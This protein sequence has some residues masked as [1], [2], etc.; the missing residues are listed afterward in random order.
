MR[1]FLVAFWLGIFS[2]NAIAA[3]TVTVQLEMK[4]GDLIP[5]TFTVPAN[6]R[7]RIEVRNTGTS[8]VEFES[9]QLRK[10][11]VLAPGA[12]SVVVIARLRPGTYSFFDDFHLDKPHG[13]IIAE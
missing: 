3:E 9:T 1:H 8:P 5:N 12:K 10:E 13:T 4:D 6:T 2:L 7:I 11:K